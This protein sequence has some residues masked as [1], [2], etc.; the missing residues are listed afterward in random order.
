[1]VRGF[2]KTMA[3]SYIIRRIL[4]LLHEMFTGIVI[5]YVIMQDLMPFYY[6][7]VGYVKDR[8]KTS[9]KVLSFTC[10]LTPFFQDK[11]LAI[12][13]NPF[14]LSIEEGTPL[15]LKTREVFFPPVR[16]KGAEPTRLLLV[17]SELCKTS[18]NL[19]KLKRNNWQVIAN[20]PPEMKKRG[21]VNYSEFIISIILY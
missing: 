21:I 13:S 6:V 8:R 11:G 17:V 5:L 16:S 15:L 4:A 2:N 19:Q 10:N 18:Q 14:S 3:V 9:V 7:P 20:I 1:M 12:V